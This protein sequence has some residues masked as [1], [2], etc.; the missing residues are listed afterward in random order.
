MP[1]RNSKPASTPEEGKI[2]PGLQALLAELEQP[3]SPRTGGPGRPAKN[4][5]K[6]TPVILHLYT[7]HIQWLD[8]Y[9]AML[10]SVDPESTRLSRVEIVRGLL[11]G[12]GQFALENQMQLPAGAKIQ[13]ERDLQHAIATA[14]NE[15]CKTQK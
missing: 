10:E 6:T 13:S 15:V 3:A 12:L 7:S 9:A 5:A 11:L 4:R 2:F 8:D 1:A 14:L